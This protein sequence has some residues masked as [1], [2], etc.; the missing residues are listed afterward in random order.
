M[1]NQI[2]NMELWKSVEKTDAKFTKRAKIGQVNITAIDPQYQKM[3]ATNSFGPYGIGWGIVSGSENQAMKEYPNQTEIM[4]YT[5][6][7]FYKWKGERGEIPIGAQIQSAYVTKQGKGYLLIDSEALKKVRTNAITKGLSELGFN[8]DVFLGKYDDQQYIQQM[9]LESNNAIAADFE[10]NIISAI[11]NIDVLT[12]RNCEL[13]A[14][15]ENI[16]TLNMMNKSY[17][18]AINR[19]CSEI[20]QNPEPHQQKLAAAYNETKT[21]LESK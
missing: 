7:L 4:T 19:E 10:D 13:L 8:A 1:N 16:A 17:S 12:T 20:K 21:K 14:T 9:V 18:N 3:N 6:I 15:C 2:D 11:S 5:A